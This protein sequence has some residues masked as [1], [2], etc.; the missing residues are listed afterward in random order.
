MIVL[1]FNLKNIAKM[2][3]KH[4]HLN[5]NTLLKCYKNTNT[6]KEQVFDKFS[7]PSSILSVPT[8]VHD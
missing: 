6:K 7:F 8:I 5:L 1:I 2:S 4:K 3:Q